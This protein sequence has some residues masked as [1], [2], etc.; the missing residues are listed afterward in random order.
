MAK[1]ITNDELA[2]MIKDSFES[3]D[4]KID[5]LDAKVDI[6]QGKLDNILYKEVTQ[7]EGRVNKIEQHLGF[8]TI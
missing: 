1:E 7:L 6:I 4:A 3:T 5:K 2:V 8:K